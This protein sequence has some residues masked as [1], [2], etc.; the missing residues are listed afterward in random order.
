MLTEEAINAFIDNIIMS[1]KYCQSGIAR[2][3]IR[4]LIVQEARNYKAE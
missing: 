3:I 1:K 4:N 2:E